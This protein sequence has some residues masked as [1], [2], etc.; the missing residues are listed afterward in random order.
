MGDRKYTRSNENVTV[1]DIDS[2]RILKKVLS[3]LKYSNVT[4]YNN[5]S[6]S[7][8]TDGIINTED[9]KL[10]DS[11]E[12]E[13]IKVGGKIYY[14]NVDQLLTTASPYKDYRFNGN[15]KTWLDNVPYSGDYS[16]SA[17]GSNDGNVVGYCFD[18]TEVNG[19]PIIT[20]G[21]PIQPSN[22]YNVDNSEYNKLSMSY[23]T[24]KYDQVGGDPVMG[25]ENLEN[26]DDDGDAM[27]IFALTPNM[28]SSD[29]I[30]M[31]YKSGI[32]IVFSMASSG[33]GSGSTQYIF[34]QVQITEDGLVTNYSW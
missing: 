29:P 11:N 1:D 2:S 15:V 13:F 20:G 33:T 8:I 28:S 3:N 10:Y 25:W 6:A 16:Y 27:N 4:C 7:G 32:H 9:I 17:S 22:L 19:Y 34:P 12:N 31:R 21:V 14:G 24:Y 26:D 23:K 18:D 5:V 30:L